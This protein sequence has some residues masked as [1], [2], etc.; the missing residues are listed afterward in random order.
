MET[1]T[2]RER[3]LNPDFENFVNEEIVP[4]PGSRPRDF[5]A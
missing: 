4:K 5:Q 3:W 2:D 1:N